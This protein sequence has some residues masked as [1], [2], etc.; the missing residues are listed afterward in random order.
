MRIRLTDLDET[1]GGGGGRDEE[2]VNG[3]AT[4]AVL[5]PRLFDVTLSRPPS[6]A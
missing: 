5:A 3:D 4:T 6:L 2:I 1:H